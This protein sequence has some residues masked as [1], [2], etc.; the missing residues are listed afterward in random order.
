MEIAYAIL[1]V[2]RLSARRPAR[3]HRGACGAPSP[4]R[5][6]TRS[7][8]RCRRVSEHAG[9]V[10]EAVRTLEPLVQDPV[11]APT[12]DAL[13]IA[14]ARADAR[15]MPAG[16]SSGWRGD[17]R[18]AAAAREPRRARLGQRDVEA[19]A[20]TSDGPWRS[21]RLVA[22]AGRPGGDGVRNGRSRGGVQGLGARVQ[23]D[24]NNFDACSASHKPR[25]RRTMSDARPYP[26]AV[27][28][29]APPR[30]YDQLRGV[31]LLLKRRGRVRHDLHTSTLKGRP[32]IVDGGR[33]SAR[34]SCSERRAAEVTAPSPFCSSETSTDS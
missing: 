12:R 32:H 11:A 3:G 14:Y 18:G 17:C 24:P 20:G 26:R 4:R 29:S 28:D 21:R 7:C 13:G 15:T 31:S 33:G 9:Q 16:R 34:R 6:R 19:P 27:H 30:L 10:A 1:G 23:L 25:A 22:C 8:W 5:D 2:C